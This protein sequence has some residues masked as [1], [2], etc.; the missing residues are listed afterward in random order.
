MGD[1]L[2][3]SQ[4]TEVL[5]MVFNTDRKDMYEKNKNNLSNRTKFAIKKI[6][7]WKQIK[8]KQ[9]VI[10]KQK[11]HQKPNYSRPLYNWSVKCAMN[12][13]FPEAR[14]SLTKARSVLLTSNEIFFATLQANAFN[15]HFYVFV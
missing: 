8:A 14:S 6:D 13:G 9:T 11:S 7:G 12:V 4:E 5:G 2:A 1:K 15:P 3:V 10:C